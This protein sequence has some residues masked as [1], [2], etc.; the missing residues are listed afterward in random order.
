MSTY[1]I[2]S[3]AVGWGR[4]TR[5]W[6]WLDGSFLGGAHRRHRS[7]RP[8]LAHETSG[9]RCWH[10]QPQDRHQRFL[11][12]FARVVA[13]G[14]NCHLWGCSRVLFAVQQSGSPKAEA[15]AVKTDTCSAL[16][17]VVQTG[18]PWRAR[19]RGEPEGVLP[20][21]HLSW[22]G[23]MG[24]IS[25]SSAPVWGWVY[26]AKWCSKLWEWRSRWCASRT[27]QQV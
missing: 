4:P 2:S 1:Q 6:C 17:R 27:L 10:N 18:A 13:L 24:V 3:V 23:M 14:R 5:G 16:V 9:C 7:R 15:A 20:V 21:L 25:C 19:S 26:L 22:P 12:L 11:N 8:I